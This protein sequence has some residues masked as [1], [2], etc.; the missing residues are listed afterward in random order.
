[1]VSHRASFRNHTA[2]PSPHRQPAADLPSLLER[3][4]PATGEAGNRTQTAF[5]WESRVQ[6]SESKGRNPESN[7]SDSESPQGKLRRPTSIC[8]QRVLSC[9]RRISLH[10]RRRWFESSGRSYT[11]AGWLGGG[12]SGARKVHQGNPRDRP[13]SVADQRLGMRHPSALYNQ[14]PHLLA[15][16]HRMLIQLAGDIQESSF[17][18]EYGRRRLYLC[19]L[20]RRVLQSARAGSSA[21]PRLARERIG[22]G[23]SATSGASRANGRSTRFLNII[24]TGC[25]PARSSA[26]LRTD[27]L[28]E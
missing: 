28:H 20:D 14:R 21:S 26:D 3:L 1:M 2:S 22:R 13:S 18:R 9:Q 19:L 25:R 10:V 6:C 4:R 5:G 23:L 8:R 15:I 27:Q 24:M 11:F 16:K 7:L 12:G 17:V